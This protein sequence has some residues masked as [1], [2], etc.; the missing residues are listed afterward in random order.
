LSRWQPSESWP[1]LRLLQSLRML[2]YSLLPP[3]VLL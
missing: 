2:V 3:Y 1:M